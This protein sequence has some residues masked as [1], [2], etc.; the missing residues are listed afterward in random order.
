MTGEGEIR[1]WTQGGRDEKTLATLN[2][3]EGR[4]FPRTR[5]ESEVDQRGRRGET[6]RKGRREKERKKE[7]ERERSPLP[8]GIE[9]AEADKRVE[10][11]DRQ[12]RTAV[13]LPASSTHVASVQ[14]LRGAALCSAQQLYT[15]HSIPRPRSPIR[16]AWPSIYFPLLSIP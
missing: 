9:Q 12:D 16:P 2:R 10:Q 1:E 6:G 11:N 3:G 4:L 5:R 7:R 14:R 8:R 15:C 13:I